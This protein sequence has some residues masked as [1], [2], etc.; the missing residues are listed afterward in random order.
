MSDNLYGALGATQPGLGAQMDPL[1]TANQHAFG[2]PAPSAEPAAGFGAAPANATIGAAPAASVKIGKVKTK[3]PLSTGKKVMY[4]AGGILFAFFALILV[5]DPG[6][7]KI[8][9]SPTPPATPPAAAEQMGAPGASGDTA[10]LMGGAPAPAPVDAAPGA[11]HAVV[12]TPAA[13]APASAPAPAPAATPVQPA[14]MPTPAPTPAPAPAAVAAAAP[15]PAPAAQPVEP[16]PAAAPPE[17]LVMVKEKAPAVTASPDELASRVATL[18][19]R[20][21]RYEREEARQRAQAAKAAAQARVAPAQARVAAPAPA[22]AA[23]PTA[24]YRPVS[25]SSAVDVR[26]PAM[27]SNDSVRVIGV[28]TRHGATTALVDFG[29]VK[30]RVAAGEAIPGLG[31]VGSVAVDAAGNPVVEVNGVRYQ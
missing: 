15:A 18:E 22:P 3:K 7:Q 16:K 14:P 28:S 6:P 5:L 8:N 17:K 21:A 26:R 1:G 10:T 13:A 31:T 29:G 4:G 2:Q 24:T 27:L 20:L 19:K 12:E 30:H 9:A 23:L 25:A 11:H